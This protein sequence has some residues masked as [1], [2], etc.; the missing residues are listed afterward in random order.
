M[1]KCGGPSEGAVESGSYMQTF[2]LVGA[3]CKP[4]GS[5]A[6]EAY[7]DVLDGAVVA[8]LAPCAVASRG[9]AVGCDV[10]QS[11]IAPIG[12]SERGNGD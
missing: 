1:R 6:T 5:R 7:L 10:Q 8:Q 4:R 11:A 12:N 3:S 2:W 9:E